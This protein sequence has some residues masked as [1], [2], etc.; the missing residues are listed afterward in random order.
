GSDSNE[1][2]WLPSA[3]ALATGE[4]R[5]QV[6]RR[7]LYLPCQTLA[8]LHATD[9]KGAAHSP[10]DSSTHGPTDSSAYGPADRSANS[11][12]NCSAYSS[13]D[14]RA[15]VVRVHPE[16]L[17]HCSKGRSSRLP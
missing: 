8:Q 2:N 12:A 10:T 14:R 15:D 5:R 3:V 6:R 4:W 16:A 1:F 17:S 11:S 9:C 13:A 7:H